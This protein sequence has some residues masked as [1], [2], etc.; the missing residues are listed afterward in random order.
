MTT[1]ATPDVWVRGGLLTAE[2]R[3]RMGEAIWV[4]L[5]L[6]KRVRFDGE[7]AGETP[8]EQPYRH[9]D[10]AA[11]LGYSESQ[12]KRLFQRL[13]DQG[14]ITTRRLPYGL[15]V[16]ILKYEGARARAERRR[17]DA[18]QIR[19][20][21]SDTSGQ[22]ISDPSRSRKSELSRSATSDLSDLDAERSAT[23]ELSRSRISATEIAHIC[24]PDSAD[25]LPRS[26][27]SDTS[28]YKDARAANDSNESSDSLSP[29][30]K[31]PRA[32]RTGALT[33]HQLL[34]NA[35]LEAIG[36]TPTAVKDYR[37][38]VK[39]G[40]E[41]AE[42]GDTPHDV[43]YCTKYLLTDDWRRKTGHVPTLEQVRDALPIWAEDGRP[44]RVGLTARRNGRVSQTDV[45]AARLREL[46]EHATHEHTTQEHE[47][48]G[49]THDDRPGRPLTAAGLRALPDGHGPANG[50][51]PA[52]RRVGGLGRRAADGVVERAVGQA[53]DHQRGL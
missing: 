15:H 52:A 39:T 14:Y 3:K 7:H 18:S 40:A 10:M 12:V 45:V 16:S 22:V 17:T 25:M 21:T 24:T 1:V 9:A 8:A 30:E 26:R 28:L 38:Y 19:S 41:M 51:L 11:H 33:A 5:E 49:D 42:R 6:H 53:V 27:I 31:V 20:A 48:G 32:A 34:I 43:R 29:T 37:R 4:Y 35:Y 47:H 46:R 2:H 13:V 50:E 36:R 44:S 23:S